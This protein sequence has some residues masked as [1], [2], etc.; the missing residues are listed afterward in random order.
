MVRERTDYPLRLAVVV[1]HPD[2]NEASVICESYR[3][4]IEV[5]AAEAKKAQPMTIFSIQK[6]TGKPIDRF[7]ISKE[8]DL[9]HSPYRKS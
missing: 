8:G 4:A 5:I 7:G 3:Q 1:I 6:H 2:G 9:V